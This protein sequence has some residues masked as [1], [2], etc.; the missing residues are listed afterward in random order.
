MMRNHENELYALCKAIVMT[1]VKYNFDETS[2]KLLVAY[3]N[4]LHPELRKLKEEEE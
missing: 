4:S 2:C 3:A 1:Q